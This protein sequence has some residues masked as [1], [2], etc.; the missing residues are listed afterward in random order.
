MKGYHKSKSDTDPKYWNKL[1]AKILLGFSI[2]GAVG[3]GIIAATISINIT[4]ISLALLWAIP[5]GMMI[6]A[7]VPSILI[8]VS[9]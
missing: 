3:G 9:A 2:V 5:L 6:G 4:G 7:L 1:A 8:A